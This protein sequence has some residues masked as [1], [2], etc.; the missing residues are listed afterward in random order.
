MLK[1]A[2]PRAAAAVRLDFT[3]R[4]LQLCIDDDGRGAAAA[5]AGGQGING[6]TERVGLYDGTVAAAP[7]TGGGFRVQAFIP[8][9]EA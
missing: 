2:G 4:G 6:M 7:R 1:H 3:A 9:T 8:Y 5:S